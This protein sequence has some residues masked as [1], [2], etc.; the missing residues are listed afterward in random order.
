[1]RTKAIENILVT[2]GY[3]FIGSNFIDFILNK[4]SKN[5][6]Y[7]SV[8]NY[9]KVTYAGNPDN[10]IHLADDNRFKFICGDICDEKIFYKALE[11]NDI[12]VV[13]NFAAESHVDKSIHSP[14]DFIK[15]NIIGTYSLL[16]AMKKF[17]KVKKDIIFYHISTDEV[18]GSL[19]L[20]ESP[21][22]EINQYK[23]NSPYSASK[24]ASDHLVRA[25][26]HTFE[27]PV[28]TSNCSNN[29]GPFQF[30]EKLIPLS[31]INALNGKPISIYGDGKNIRD[32][33]YVQDHC[34]AIE[35]ILHNGQ[36]G[37]VY[38]IGGNNE[39]TNIDVIQSICHNLEQLSP[40]VNNNKIKKGTSYKD[41]ITY[42]KDRPGHDFRY[43][44]NSSKLKEKLNWSPS[45]TFETGIKKTVSWYLNNPKW[46]DRI[47]NKN[48]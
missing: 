23:P 46:I 20:N 17:Y 47:H 11:D 22:E 1:M 4:S 2:G 24:A 21:F 36:I 13:V 19:D 29:Y 12:D 5:K 33:L 43:S 40:S 7:K 18:Y 34:D 27:L 44:I 16:S 39:K 32:W 26:N 31:I 10:L 30:P 42:V 14:Y 3:G 6:N 35:N 37:E 25:W 28:I 45:N 41:L 48:D 15:T 8:I 38:N 9:D